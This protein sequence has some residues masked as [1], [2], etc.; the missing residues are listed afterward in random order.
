MKQ[1]GKVSLFAGLL[2]LHDAR[3]VAWS[4][5]RS[6]LQDEDAAGHPVQAGDHGVL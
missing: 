4:N 1:S 5:S 6:D 3:Q 2:L